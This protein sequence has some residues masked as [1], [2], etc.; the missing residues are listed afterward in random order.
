MRGVLSLA[1]VLLCARSQEE[2]R[3]PSKFKV[4]RL[5]D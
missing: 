5:V 4:S 1:L 2:E 3:P